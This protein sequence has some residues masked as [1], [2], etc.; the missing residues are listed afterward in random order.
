LIALAVAL[1]FLATSDLEP[2]TRTAAAFGVG[3]G[4]G[5]LL[6]GLVLVARHPSVQ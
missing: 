6:L 2:I 4:T 5:L 3:E 1:A